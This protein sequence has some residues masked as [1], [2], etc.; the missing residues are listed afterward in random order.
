M[1][2]VL[3]P[4]FLNTQMYLRLLIVFR[5]VFGLDNCHTFF[6]LNFLGLFQCLFVSSPLSF[7]KP[8]NM[9][10]PIPGHCVLRLVIRTKY[11]IN[12]RPE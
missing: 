11:V 3:L 5:F 8:L 7:D 4:N 12:L 2:N 9:V 6:S 10:L 1:V